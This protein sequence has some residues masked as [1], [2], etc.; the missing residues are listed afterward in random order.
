[1]NIR[2]LLLIFALS[3]CSISCQKEAVSEARASGSQVNPD[4]ELNIDTCC[5]E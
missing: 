2:T 3:L 4:I 5:L 1:M